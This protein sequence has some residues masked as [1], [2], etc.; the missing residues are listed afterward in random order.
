MLPTSSGNSDAWGTGSDCRASTEEE[1]IGIGL[2]YLGEESVTMANGT[3]HNSAGADW[4][5]V[6][7]E[8]GDDD[9][10]AGGAM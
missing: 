10:M 2:L 1:T 5:W 3:L 7:V 4:A 6:D 9:I 8:I